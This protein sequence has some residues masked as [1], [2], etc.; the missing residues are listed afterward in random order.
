MGFFDLMKSNAVV[1]FEKELPNK[2]LLY[3]SYEKNI[4]PAQNH[5]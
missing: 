2:D 1:S 3:I 5:Q 4:P